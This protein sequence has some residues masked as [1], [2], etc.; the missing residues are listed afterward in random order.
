M[1]T[2]S[3]IGFLIGATELMI[4]LLDNTATKRHDRNNSKSVSLRTS[5]GTTKGLQRT[6]H[7]SA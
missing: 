4:E 6:Q 1:L 3:I 7:L 2:I 5:D